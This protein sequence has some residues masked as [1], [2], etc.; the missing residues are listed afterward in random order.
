[1]DSRY[2][3]QASASSINRSS[4][5]SRLPTATGSP[6]CRWRDIRSGT[7]R[8]DLGA[9]LEIPAGG[10]ADRDGT[11][12]RDRALQRPAEGRDQRD[13]LARDR[14]EAEARAD[15]AEQLGRARAVDRLAV[16][17]R[18]AQREAD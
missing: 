2:S 13:A 12:V 5:A 4:W 8:I 6:P 7:G 11:G 3:N 17:D 15:D 18:D 1:M 10:L 14:A 9:E 16:C